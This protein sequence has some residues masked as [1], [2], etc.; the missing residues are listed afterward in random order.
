MSRSAVV[1]GT[2]VS[3]SAAAPAAQ[4]NEGVRSLG[5]PVQDKGN[6]DGWTNFSVVMPSLSFE[7]EGEVVRWRWWAHNAAGVKFVVYRPTSDARTFTVVG[8]NEVT[9]TRGEGEHEVTVG[10]R[11][12]V[13]AGDCI[14]L[15]L[16][17]PAAIPFCR[18][19]GAQVMWGPNRDH[20]E[21]AVGA[22]LQVPGGGDS[23]NGRRDYAVAA[24]WAPRRPAAPTAPVVAQKL[25]GADVEMATLT[26][27]QYPPLMEMGRKFETEFGLSGSL[28]Q[29]V[30]AAAALVGVDVAGKALVQKAESTWDVAFGKPGDGGAPAFA[31]GGGSVQVAVVSTQPGAD[32]ANLPGAVDG[33]P[34]LTLVPA[35]AGLR[36]DHAATLRA[37]GAAPLTARGAHVGPYW[38]ATRDAW[39]HWSYIDLGVS[40]AVQPLT[41]KLEGP[42]IVWYGPHGEMVFDVSMWQ[43]VA[44]RHLVV[45]KATP[46][47]P[48]GPTRM[49]KDAAGRDFVLHDDGTPLHSARRAIRPFDGYFLLVGKRRGS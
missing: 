16:K 34:R 27:G 47:N 28:P 10:C 35:V 45:V 29:V 33:A 14:G 5:H 6:V 43:L 46:G 1:M 19:S 37:G 22:V 8:V 4:G 12:H 26:P 15:R 31:P 2:V 20:A 36:F 49:S 7:A 18:D 25:L 11:I 13:Q 3:V 41:V 39:G 24:D 48:G 32:H 21:P 44:G 9:T 38:H 30:D 40:G 42:Y 17:S 23:G